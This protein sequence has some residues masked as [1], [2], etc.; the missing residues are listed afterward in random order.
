MMLGKGEDEKE[1]FYKY[2]LQPYLAFFTDLVLGSSEFLT[3]PSRLS[4]IS[5]LGLAKIVIGANFETKR[6]IKE[7][8]EKNLK[9]KFPE[10]GPRGFL[11]G[12]IY[13]TSV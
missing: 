2:R 8:N 12:L 7:G 10:G 1:V 13:F 4:H 6:M 3:V 9:K 11:L 5:M